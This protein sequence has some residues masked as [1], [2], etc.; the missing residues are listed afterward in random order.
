MKKIT[1]QIIYNLKKEKS[2][3]VSFG[4]I[5]LITALILNC[6]AVLLSQVDRAYE[7]KLSILNTADVNGIVP[8][9]QSSSKLENNLRDLSSVEKLESHTAVMVEATVKDFNGAD[10]SMNTVF[11]NMDAKRNVNNFELVSESK[12]DVENPIYIPLYVSDFGG[13]DLGDN[14]VYAI[15]GKSHS[16][17]VAGVIEEMQYGNYGSGL[18]CAYLPKEDFEEF[19]DV[20]SEKTVVEYSMSVNSGA[21]LDKTKEDIS[22]VIE[23][24]GVMTLSLLDSESVKGTRTMVTDLLILILTAFSLIILAVSV[25]L[26]NF[27]VKN[28]IDCEIINMSVLKALGYTSAQIVWGITLP[29]ALVSLIF[30]LSGVGL[31]YALLPVLCSV[32]TVQSGFSFAVSFDLLSFI[33]VTVILVG[34]VTFF[35]FISARKIKKTQ[36]IDGLRGNTSTKGAK[37]N[38]LPLDKTKGNTKLLLVLKQ[39]IAT[40]KQNVML[41]LVSFVLTVLIAFSGT[42]FYNVVVKPE[43]FMSALSDEVADVI[44]IPKEDSIS[45]LEAKLGDDNRVENSL[46]Y[47]S[48]SVKIED[49]AVTSF[50]C[51]D[52][53]KVR[54]DVCYMGTNP[55]EVDEIA[56]GSAFEESFKIGDTVSVT[57]DDITKSFEVTG[58]VQ[59][60]NLQGELCKL[61]TEGYNSLL[62]EKQTPS[63]YVY[64][65][66]PEN[67]EE[68]VKEYKAD[69][70]E[71]L[72]DTINSYKLQKEAQDMYMGITMVLV[73]AIFVVTILVVLFILYIVIK[74]LLVKRRQELGIYKAMGYTSSQL[75]SQTAGSFMLVS[76]IATLLSSVLA[77]FYMPA[78]YGFIF[79]ALGVMKNNIEISFGFLML[80]AVAAILVN[81]II[82]IILCMPIR[83]I[84]AYS[85]IK[86]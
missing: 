37:K 16:F 39:M 5:I 58:F 65:E 28:A 75:I 77:M 57:V 15:D 12:N 18:L 52:F 64:L 44:M 10:F 86:E 56:L 20:Y 17:T 29:Y 70:P 22:K 46:Q 48:C 41:F 51:E 80:F 26:S 73:V 34:V 23:H 45:K 3:F 82:S 27:K 69:Y 8:W 9:I 24:N 67:A 63:L 60:V 7:V 14:I 1:N 47:M 30:A 81:I 54:N 83:K 36:P 25:F 84:S 55:K 19:A 76:I 74:S 78:V 32:L 62:D 21:S 42:L 59:S 71:L 53:S 2:S 79:E 4:V 13:F 72:A 49:K 68:V 31:S 33:C 35:T 61:S 40:K 38:R 66:N 85:L 43:N 11:Y 50:A 6:A